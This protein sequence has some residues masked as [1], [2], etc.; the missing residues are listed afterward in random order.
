MAEQRRQILEVPFPVKGLNK[1]TA[2]RGQPKG[3]TP[4]AQN[5]RSFEPMG[6]RVR[7]GRR[8]GLSKFYAL[9]PTGAA[10]PIQLMTEVVR[11]IPYGGEVQTYLF[12]VNEEPVAGEIA[13]LHNKDVALLTAIRTS[14]VRAAAT[15]GLGC[16]FD[17]DGCIYVMESGVGATYVHKMD[18]NTF[19]IIWSW[20]ADTAAAWAFWY[21]LSY[22]PVNNR[23]IVVGNTSNT[24]TGAGGVSAN[25]WALGALT[26]TVDWSYRIG[27]AAEAARSSQVDA[28][29]AVYIGGDLTAWW[30]GVDHGATTASIWKLAQSG[31]TV[32]T[33]WAVQ[34][35]TLYGTYDLALNEAGTRLAAVGRRRTAVVVNMFEN[36]DLAAP[37]SEW[38]AD[39]TNEYGTGVVMSS[40]GRPIVGSSNA[41]AAVGT[42]QCFPALGGAADWTYDTGDRPYLIDRDTDDAVYIPVDRNNVWTDA[43]GNNATIIKLTAAGAYTTYYDHGVGVMES[44]A[45]IAFRPPVTPVN[46]TI[47]AFVV[48][49]GGNVY[50]YRKNSI[51]LATG[52]AGALSTELNVVQ[53][54]SAYGRTYLVD[55]VNAMRYILTTMTVDDWAAAALAAHPGHPLPSNCRLICRYRGRIVLSGNYAAPH[56]WYM[57]RVNDPLDWDYAPATTDATIPVAGNNCEAGEMGDIITALIPCDD[58]LLLFGGDHSI[59]AMTGDPAAGG[60]IDK[61]SDQTGIRHGKAW[62]RDPQGNVYF[63]GTGG[64]YRFGPK[65]GELNNLTLGRLDNEFDDV[66]WDKYRAY[67]TWDNL[68]N[69]FW[70][71]L[72]SNDSTNY[73]TRM[74]YWDGYAD[75]WWEDVFP[76]SMGPC[77]MSFFDGVN[78]DD[79]AMLMGSLDGYIR[80]TDD[81]SL[82]DDGTVIV[83]YVAFAPLSAKTPGTALL[84]SQIQAVMAEDSADVELMVGGGPTEESAVLDARSAVQRTLHA[85][86]NATLHQR[87]RGGAIVMRLVSVGGP[88]A[89]ESL[90]VGIQP[91]GLQRR[92]GSY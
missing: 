66:N 40:A 71:L 48:V 26:G 72:I 74:Y 61:L 88:W 33:T 39:A 73:P 70:L 82:T 14:T 75:A 46:P 5:V 23:V 49:S 43:A 68:H 7:G 17:D 37:T 31:S 57:S 64:V 86:R 30:G 59:Y 60:I 41:A 12:S 53:A 50:T 87:V 18:P 42:V 80:K 85:G 19:A 13:T 16:C 3:T 22:D 79:R 36:L 81:T 28:T 38:T 9:Q 67:L 83:A 91:A 52:G 21:R 10:N 47:T 34:R 56:N 65:T 24:W 25:V 90:G 11:A 58:D 1:G 54:V 77:S 20:T 8:P 2:L 69:G 32:S 15:R 92:R 35:V 44:L 76:T 51:G 4:S 27:N 29:G 89:L 45:V 6:K 84:V 63:M 55:G 62:T 78:P